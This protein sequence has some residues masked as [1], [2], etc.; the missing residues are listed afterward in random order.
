MQLEM[1]Y[2]LKLLGRALGWSER[3]CAS[4]SLVPETKRARERAFHHSV[5][6]SQLHPG[7]PDAQNQSHGL[8]S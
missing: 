4:L 1:T 3:S 5:R 6:H 7:A 2:S 8:A